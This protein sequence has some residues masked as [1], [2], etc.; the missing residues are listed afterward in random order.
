MSSTGS[1]MVQNIFDL[2]FNIPKGSPIKSAIM[3]ATKT[4]DRV[5]IVACH[6]PILII[7]AKLTIE[8]I[9]TFILATFQDINANIAI[10][11]IGGMRIRTE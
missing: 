10:S 9:A 2:A 3:V 8:N 11:K 5:C 7:R 4:K 1:I 6:N